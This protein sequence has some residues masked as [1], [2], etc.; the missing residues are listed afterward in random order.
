MLAERYCP[1]EMSEDILK[2]RQN[3]HCLVRI[4]LGRRRLMHQTQRRLKFFSLRNFPLHAD[5]VEELNLPSEAY[6]KGMA[7]ALANLHWRVRT[8]GADVE[9]FLGAPRGIENADYPLAEHS[10]WMLDYDCSRPIEADETGLRA[11]ARAFWRKDPYFPRPSATDVQSQ[12]LWEIFSAE[13][14]RVGREIVKAYPREGEDMEALLA[15]VDDALTM[16]EDTKGK[17]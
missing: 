13:Y 14:R 17:F 4:Y 5:Q 1:A 12:S 7:E 10:L 9:F 15:L 3:H 2:S 11:I 16:I 8:D 6:T